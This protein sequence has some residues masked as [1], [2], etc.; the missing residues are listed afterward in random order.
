MPKLEA[1]LQFMF[2]EYDL[3][4]RYDAAARAGFKGVEL[5]APYS[6]PIP[7][8]VERLE[9]NN[10]KHVIINS[11]SADPDT[12]RLNISLRADRVDLYK[13]R[14]AQAAEYAAGLGCIGVNIGC[15]EID[16]IDPD[17]ARATLI[18]NMRHAAEELGKVG[19]VAL[20]EAINT[21]DRPG[22]FINTTKQALDTIA[23]ADHPNLAILYDFYH[24]QIMEGDL[25]LTV[26]ENLS[27]IKHMQLADNPG[28]HEPGT[29]EIN[30]DNLLQHLDEIGYEGWVGCE[31]NPSGNTEQTLGWASAWL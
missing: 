17:E 14:T 7:Q 2:N 8:I 9:R 21:R 11:A 22:F 23:E 29:G 19:V 30:Y 3:I 4:D 13:E 15:G 24:M 31:Y 20:V 18:S 5:Q 6:L 12:G 25:T 10:L 27:S 16:D 1:N 26:K 28:R